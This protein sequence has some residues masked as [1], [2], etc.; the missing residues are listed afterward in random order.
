M[1]TAALFLAALASL[2][3]VG[4]SAEGM[5]KCVENGKT[6]YQ[7]EPCPA[8][9]RQDSFKTWES[10]PAPAA[11]PAKADV[12]RT[13][14][15]MSTYRACAD[16]VKVWGDEMAAPYEQW[17]SRNSEVVAR[18]EGEHELQARYQQRVEAKRHGKASMCRDV[19]LE[20]RGK[21]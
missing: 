3:C 7:S 6:L 9:A 10:S 1:K 2:A 12:D 11:A 18:I 17:R 15:F 21:K 5:Y 19:A 4:A 13:I 14:E 20:L 16:G 8:T